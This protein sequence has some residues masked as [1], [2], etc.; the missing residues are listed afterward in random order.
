MIPLSTPSAALFTL[1]VL[2]VAAAIAAAIGAPL[3]DDDDA[4]ARRWR[5]IAAVGALAWL[6]L[7]AL[8]AVTGLLAAPG[9]WLVVFVAVFLGSAVALAA[10][11]AGARAARRPLWAL[12]GFQVFRLPLEMLLHAWYVHGSVPVQMT[13]SGQ[14]LDVLSGLL[15]APFLLLRR[16]PPRPLAWAVL[17]LQLALLAN[18]MRIA[19]TSAPTPLRQFFDEP[20]LLLPLYWP[21]TWIVPVCVAGALLGH[22][23][24]L[25]HLYAT[26]RAAEPAAGPPAAR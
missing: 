15:A 5:T 18:V 19:L 21:S 26:P 9:P 24:T 7:S 23:V 1:I 22:L 25:R 3:P 6:I 8:P 17:A 20:T 16:D 14:N 2:L 4:T 13:W 10:S 11:P 12:L